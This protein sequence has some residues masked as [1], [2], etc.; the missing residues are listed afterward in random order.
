[1]FY[2]ARDP[3]FS[4][5]TLSIEEI[6]ALL[7]PPRVE[8]N[9]PKVQQITIA[10]ISESEETDGNILEDRRTGVRP[11][12]NGVIQEEMDQVISEGRDDLMPDD[13]IQE[14][15]DETVPAR[16]DVI[17]KQDR[18]HEKETPDNIIPEESNNT[19]SPETSDESYIQE[20]VAA[21]ES[22]SSEK[23]GQ[24]M[25]RNAKFFLIL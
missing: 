3:L 8:R 10:T 4:A 21:M 18:G 14:K 15:R 22:N 23:T 1:M 9:E 19:I 2:Y 11:E 17:L 16:S 7:A 20:S 12:K 6:R 13:T 24:G 25:I 5:K